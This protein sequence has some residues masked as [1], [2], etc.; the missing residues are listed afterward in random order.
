[1]RLNSGSNVGEK[2]TC[3]ILK[4]MQLHSFFKQYVPFNFNSGNMQFY[5]PNRFYTNAGLPQLTTLP[6]TM[7]R[8]IDM[9]CAKV[10]IL[11]SIYL[12]AQILM[13]QK[14]FQTPKSFQKVLSKLSPMDSTDTLLSQISVVRFFFY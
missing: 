4:V 2:S 12:S 13:I 1:M 6:L 5:L 8:S 7:G 14:L 3:K 11:K 10:D 9:V